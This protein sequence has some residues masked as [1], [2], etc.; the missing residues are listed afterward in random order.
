[1]MKTLNLFKHPSDFISVDA[2]ETIFKQGQ[3]T[4]LMYVDNLSSVSGS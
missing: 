4:E 3:V 2:G 1:M